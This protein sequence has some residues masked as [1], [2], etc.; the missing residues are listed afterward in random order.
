MR[1]RRDE[2]ELGGFGEQAHPH[3]TGPILELVKCFVHNTPADLPFMEPWELV[4]AMSRTWL[5]ITA[6]ALPGAGP[7]GDSYRVGKA[8][9]LAGYSLSALQAGSGTGDQSSL[10]S[11]GYYSAIFIKQHVKGHNT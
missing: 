10:F 7:A 9:R 1:K 3:C 6:P 5:R 8:V 11:S 2:D 4:Q